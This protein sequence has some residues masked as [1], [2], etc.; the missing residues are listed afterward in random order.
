MAF[1]QMKFLTL[2]LWV[3]TVLTIGLI[4][5]VDRPSLWVVVAAV[6]I[7]PASVASWVWTA[8]PVILSQ[9]IQKYRK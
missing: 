5:T 4:V 3:A 2:S 1:E 7:I 9:L 6:A 8:P